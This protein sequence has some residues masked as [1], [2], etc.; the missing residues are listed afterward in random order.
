MK[1]LRKKA[2]AI[3][4]MAIMIMAAISL[5]PGHIMERNRLFTEENIIQYRMI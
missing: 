3:S 4:A 5:F 2:F 1:L